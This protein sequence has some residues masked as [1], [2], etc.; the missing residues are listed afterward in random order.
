MHAGPLA[1]FIVSRLTLFFEEESERA[2]T[3]HDR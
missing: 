3:T 1:W 2:K